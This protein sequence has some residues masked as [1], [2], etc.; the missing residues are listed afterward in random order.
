MFE[1][2]FGVFAEVVG[3]IENFFGV[4]AEV[5]GVIKKFF[6]VFAEA[7]GVFEKF[8]GMFAEAFG[9]IAGFAGVSKKDFSPVSFFSVKSVLLSFNFLFLFQEIIHMSQSKFLCPFG[10]RVPPASVLSVAKNFNNL[11]NCQKGV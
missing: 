3:V 8:F 9:V 6:G 5:F 2:F 7:F 10:L 1:K 4:L 11:C